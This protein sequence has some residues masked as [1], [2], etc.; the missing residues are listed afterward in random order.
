[1]TTITLITPLLIV[2]PFIVGILFACLATD[3]HF[4]T[5]ILIASFFSFAAGV[6]QNYIINHY[7]LVPITHKYENRTTT[8]GN[9][10]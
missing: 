3:G 8:L 9:N 6:A 10:R 2:I 5:A 4:L 1:M 7:S